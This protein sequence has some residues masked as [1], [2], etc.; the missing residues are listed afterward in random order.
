MA[1]PLLDKID[2]IDVFFE[3]HGVA[4]CASSSRCTAE[5]PLEE[6]RPKMQLLSMALDGQEPSQHNKYQFVASQVFIDRYVA[7][8]DALEH[9]CARLGD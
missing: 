1:V 9:L 8:C 6:F 4:C 7:Y 2:D 3:S 5:C